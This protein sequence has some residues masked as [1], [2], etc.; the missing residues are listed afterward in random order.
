MKALNITKNVLKICG[1]CLRVVLIGATLPLFVVFSSLKS[2]RVE[3][4][5]HIL[6]TYRYVNG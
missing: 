6:S 4:K 5:P 3:R 2:E 1:V